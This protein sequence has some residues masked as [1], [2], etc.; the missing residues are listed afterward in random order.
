M[1]NQITYQ[2]DGI[3]VNGEFLS[4]ESIT[5]NCLLKKIKEDKLILM[6]KKK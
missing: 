5:E 6:E 2:K 4:L 1:K 3:I